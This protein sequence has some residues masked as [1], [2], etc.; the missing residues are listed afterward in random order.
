PGRRSERCVVP[1]DEGHWPAV[2]QDVAEGWAEVAVV[3]HE[4]GGGWWFES[5]PD[6]P[7]VPQCLPC[8]LTRHPDLVQHADL[9]LNWAAWRSADGAWT[10]GPRPAEWGPWDE[11]DSD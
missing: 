7:G 11:T 10:R 1:N 3:Y 8:L 2:T 9:P 4:S 6:E 5:D